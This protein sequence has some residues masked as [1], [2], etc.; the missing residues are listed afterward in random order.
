[1]STEAVTWAMDHAPML[2]TEKG[3][4]DTTA[5]HVL[6]V[7]AEHASPTGTDAHPSV[8]RIQYRTGYD[9]TT[10]QRALR[11]LEKGELIAKDGMKE[12]RTRWKL[13]MYLHRPATDWSDLEREEDEF[14][15]A[16]AERKR[17]S[18]SKGVTHAESVTVT[19]AEGV[20][21]THAESVTAD[22]THSKS[23]RH[24]LKVRPSRTERRPNHQQ[25]SDNQLLKDSS[26][27]TEPDEQQAHTAPVQTKSSS[28]KKD[29]HLAAFGAFW[30]NYPKKRDREE[31]KKAW[32]A[33]IERGVEPKRMV[34]AAQAYARERFGQDPKFTKYPATWLNKGCYDDEP[35]PQ[36]GPH[37]RAVAG[38]YQPYRDPTDESVY[39]KD[40]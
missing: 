5:R 3:K 24:A 35:D 11:R 27:A 8:L 10:V 26:S 28:E 23:V 16:A 19:D 39:D 30:S 9:R 22:V 7:L 40:L 29:H 37:L 32:I 31:A 12:S 2:R 6:Q 20:T 33:A 14:R 1:M 15:A 36:P 34:D 17:R 18:R 13:A 25:P 21:V 4:P 38:G